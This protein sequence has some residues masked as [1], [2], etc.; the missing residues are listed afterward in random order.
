MGDIDILV[1]FYSF[2][3]NPVAS[4]LFSIL[5]I[6]V[7]IVGANGYSPLRIVSRS[8]ELYYSDFSGTVANGFDIKHSAISY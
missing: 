4:V 3:S 6:R 8:T 5:K 2:I 1:N 7:Y